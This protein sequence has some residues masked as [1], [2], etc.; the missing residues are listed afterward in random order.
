LAAVAFRTQSIALNSP[1]QRGD[2]RE[3]MNMRKN[4]LSLLLASALV[5]VSLTGLH[6]DT[7]TGILNIAGFN[8]P[9]APNLWDPNNSLVPFYSFLNG[10][11]I[12]NAYPPQYNNSVSG[13][14]VTTQFPIPVEFGFNGRNVDQFQA[15]YGAGIG[16]NGLTYTVDP[17]NGEQAA[18]D[19]YFIS[20]VTDFFDN[21]QITNNTF[22]VPGV[23]TDNM[24]S[25]VL[26][27]G[28][29]LHLHWTGGLVTPNGG[30][31][32]YDYSVTYA[33]GTGINPVPGPTIGAGI[34]GL[35]LGLIS[36]GWALTRRKQQS[37]VLAI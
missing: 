24:G 15:L 21:L 16:P 10:T 14:T 11:T 32:G 4:L 1:D 23:N 25:E 29:E 26:N 31:T 33:G 6:A 22:G 35:A 37:D 30:P 36:L 3:E 20:S 28:T 12:A 34:P 7:I 2:H 9:P 5:P 8:S 19:I 13:P 17:A 18:E 27:N